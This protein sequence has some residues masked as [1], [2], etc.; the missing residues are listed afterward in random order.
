M[1]IQVHTDK[2]I[3]GTEAFAA[4]VKGVV[5][6][7]LARVSD[8]VSRVEVHV[9]DQNSDKSGADDKR[10]MMEARME[11]QHPTAV[12]HNAAEIGD[13]IDGAADKL[14]RSL[15]STVERLHSVRRS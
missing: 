6:E 8:R 12:T 3:E 10:C 15:E 14:Q 7:A 13:A 5:E 1:L 11:G 2:N 9:S 4:H